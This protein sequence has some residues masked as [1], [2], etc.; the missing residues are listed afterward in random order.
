[1]ELEKGKQR[2]HILIK[3]KK[4]KFQIYVTS[5]VALRN[6]LKSQQRFRIKFHFVKSNTIGNH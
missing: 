2:I 6:Y 4:V 3:W 5:R 1:M